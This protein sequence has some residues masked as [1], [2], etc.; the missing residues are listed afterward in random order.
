MGK[1]H[2]WSSFLNNRSPWIPAFVSV[3]AKVRRFWTIGVARRRFW[4]FMASA[5]IY[6]DILRNLPKSWQQN[7]IYRWCLHR[8]NVILTSSHDSSKKLAN[9]NVS[10]CWVK[11]EVIGKVANPLEAHIGYDTDGRI[12]ALIA[13]GIGDRKTPKWL[14]G[15]V[16]CYVDVNCI[17]Y[18]AV[19][20]EITRRTVA[21]SAKI[22]VGGQRLYLIRAD[23]RLVQSWKVLTLRL[24]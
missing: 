21:I 22:L 10:G 15:V 13:K 23:L 5:I 1:S 18:C 3:G 6:P 12:V 4:W 19:C 17:T 24:A 11:A 9:L 8:K 2:G 14:T 20:I 16:G 7:W